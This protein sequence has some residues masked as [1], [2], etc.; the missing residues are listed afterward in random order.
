MT[1]Q[2]C[3]AIPCHW[4]TWHCRSRQFYLWPR[5]PRLGKSLA[6]KYWFCAWEGSLLSLRTYAPVNC[7]TS[8]FGWAC[9]WS[10]L[11]WEWAVTVP[12]R[13]VLSQPS[14]HRWGAC[15]LC[16]HF[17]CVCTW[18]AACC[19]QACAGSDNST[20]WAVAAGRS[21]EL[22]LS[23][24]LFVLLNVRT[25]N[26]QSMPKSDASHFPAHLPL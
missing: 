3:K 12:T 13:I 17:I 11:V 20:N 7:S 23:A 2:S 18:Q 4:R 16:R 14:R 26:D 9:R 24:Y 22:L 19:Q 8:S 6:H 21:P 10:C 15:L 25:P 1:H 5:L